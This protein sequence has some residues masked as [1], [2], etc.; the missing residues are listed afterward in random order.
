MIEILLVGLL[1]V[2]MAKRGRRGGRRK[3]QRYLRGS[4]DEAL[5][6]GTL[7]ALDVIAAAFGDTVNERT[8][9][10]SVVFRWSL[11][12]FTKSTGD[13][14]I[15]V[16]VSHSDYTAPEI[17]EWIENS[18][19]WDEGNLVQQEIAKRKIKM[20]GT[21]DNPADEAEVS[22]LNDGKPITT[23]CKWILNQ[24]QTLNLWV[25][26]MGSSPLATTSPVVACFGYANL[27]PR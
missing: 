18:D 23:K 26:N 9:V 12:A 13:G 22:I 3:F 11:S 17:E 6:L 7:A 25:Y 27:W 19:S 20:V 4:V 8:F 21:F 16:G 5:A 2:S 1:L 24:G 15:L 14:P 10:S